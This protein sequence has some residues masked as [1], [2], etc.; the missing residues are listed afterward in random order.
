MYKNANIT[1][2]VYYGKTRTQQL[3]LPLLAIIAKC[4][5]LIREWGNLYDALLEV[6]TNKR[7][8]WKNV[9]VDDWTA[10]L[11]AITSLQKILFYKSHY[12][13]IPGN[14]EI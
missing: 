9:R 10:E 1:N 14:H 6:S 11:A 4:G 13:V 2:F 7:A 5:V 12:F 3:P 8:L